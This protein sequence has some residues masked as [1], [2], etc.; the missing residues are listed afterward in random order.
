[1]VPEVTFGLPDGREIS[2]GPGAVIG[3]A[4]VSDIWLDDGRISEMHAYVSL[5]G[6]ELVLLSLRGRIRCDERAVSRVELR[7]GQT[8]ELAPGVAL[9][10]T[11]VTRPAHVLALESL[12]FARQV[13]LG[14]TSLVLR[15]APHLVVGAIVD[16]DALFWSDGTTWRVRVGAGTVRQLRVGDEIELSGFTLRT[17][18][19]PTAGG[20]IPETSPAFTV[21]SPASERL[22]LVSRGESVQLWRGASSEPCALRGLP[23]RIVAELLAFGGPVRWEMLA[24]ELWGKE[25]ATVVVRHRLDVALLKTRRL[26]ATAGVRRDLIVSH[27]NGWIE[28]NLYPGDVADDEA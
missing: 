19:V 4:R 12:D 1:M 21:G 3:R 20:A 15:P 5:R 7:S 13:L 26:L 16:A 9:R 18:A 28:L 2:V 6:G 23:A 22:R 25:L 14:V 11:G 10:V 17:V 8:L 24:E 27:R